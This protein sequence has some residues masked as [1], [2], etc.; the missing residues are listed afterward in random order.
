MVIEHEEK[1]NPELKVVIKEGSWVEDKD[2]PNSFKIMFI[3]DDVY[4]RTEL[5]YDQM[6]VASVYSEVD[7]GFRNSIVKLMLEK[8]TNSIRIVYYTE[9]CVQDDYIERLEAYLWPING[10]NNG[11]ISDYTIPDLSEYAVDTED[12]D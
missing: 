10:K 8:E 1:I 12:W 11:I 4:L 3:V 6:N 2:F 9:E 5:H 7:K